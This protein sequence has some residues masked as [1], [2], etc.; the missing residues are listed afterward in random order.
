ME[1]ILFWNI[2]PVAWNFEKHIITKSQIIKKNRGVVSGQKIFYEFCRLFRS[3]LGISGTWKNNNSLRNKLRKEV[4]VFFRAISDF[5]FF[6]GVL[7]IFQS[8]GKNIRSF[9]ISFLCFF[10]IS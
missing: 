2:P 5:R 8:F 9:R 10:S 6:S 4:M 3:F 7:R 1:L